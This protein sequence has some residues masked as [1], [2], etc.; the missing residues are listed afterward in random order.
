MAQEGTPL[1]TGESDTVAVA[2][3]VEAISGFENPN[4][5]HNREGKSRP[6]N[7]AANV[8]GWLSFGQ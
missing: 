8:W 6:M 7:E 1:L 2:L 5:G 4:E 3:A